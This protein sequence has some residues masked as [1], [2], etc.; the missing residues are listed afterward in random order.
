MGPT[1]DWGHHHKGDTESGQALEKGF[2][3]GGACL[4]HHIRTCFRKT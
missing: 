3:R 1:E 2:Y 4:F